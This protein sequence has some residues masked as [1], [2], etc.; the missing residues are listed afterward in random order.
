MGLHRLLPPAGGGTWLLLPRRHG[1][2][3]FVSLWSKGAQV[4]PPLSKSLAL[5]TEILCLPET[6][7]PGG[8]SRAWKY[9]LLCQ[10]YSG[11]MSITESENE[12]S[13]TPS[14]PNLFGS[15][16]SPSWSRICILTLLSNLM[17]FIPAKALISQLDGLGAA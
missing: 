8:T 16:Q 3:C 10:P 1:G 17:S 5:C 2:R 11:S 12:G 9:P 15:T 4:Y 13:P 6:T 7:H 14:Q